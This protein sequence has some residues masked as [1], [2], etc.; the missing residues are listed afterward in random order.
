[1][2]IRYDANGP[3]PIFFLESRVCLTWSFV[4]TTEPFSLKSS[5]GPGSVRLERRKVH[6]AAI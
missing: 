2:D 6:R 4:N 1:M 5:F 3:L